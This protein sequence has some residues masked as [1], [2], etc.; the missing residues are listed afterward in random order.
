ME[1]KR[2]TY[3]YSGGFLSGF[4]RAWGLSM[5]AEKAKGD[6]PVKR[7]GGVRRGRRGGEGEGEA[8]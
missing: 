6:R 2:Q 8:L 5:Q 1:A 4:D 3:R 7:E